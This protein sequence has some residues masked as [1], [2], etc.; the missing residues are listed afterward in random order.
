LEKADSEDRLKPAKPPTPQPSH[1]H[2]LRHGQI[3]FLPPLIHQF[4]PRLRDLDIFDEGG[5]DYDRDRERSMEM[6]MNPVHARV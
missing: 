4:F 2:P 3:H 5:G 6:G 1:L